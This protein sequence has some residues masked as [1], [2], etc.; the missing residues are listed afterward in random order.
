MTMIPV[1]MG[2]EL[3]REMMEAMKTGNY[4]NR[5]EFIRDAIVEK[6]VSLGHDV[7]PSLARPPQ[8]VVYPAPKSR[9]VALNE[10]VSSDPVLK[11]GGSLAEIEAQA[12]ALAHRRSLEAPAPIV[13]IG[14]PSAGK[15]RRASGA[16]PGKGAQ[17]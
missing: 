15:P 12:E 10:T 14:K 11:P 8:R 2:P 4:T 13:R 1:P 7:P 6:A 17:P 3:I 5:S 9:S 16:P